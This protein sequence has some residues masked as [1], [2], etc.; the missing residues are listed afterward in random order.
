MP[1]PLPRLERTGSSVGC[2]PALR[3]P[4]PSDRRVS[5]SERLSRPIQG[6]RTFRPAH[7]HLGFAKDFSGGFSRTIT[8]LDCS[9]GY[10]ANRQFPGRDLHPLAFETQE[11]S[12]RFN[13]SR[14]TSL[15]AALPGNALSPRSKTS[16]LP[17]AATLPSLRFRLPFSRVALSTLYFSFSLPPI[18]GPPDRGEAHLLLH[19]PPRHQ[20]TLGYSSCRHDQLAVRRGPATTPTPLRSPRTASG[21]ES[22]LSGRPRSGFPP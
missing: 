2:S 21:V 11:V 5:S 20:E 9:S 4:S 19:A 15:R 14:Q 1:T 3:R 18:P 16:P 7:L 17:L 6:S 10:R 8:R 22:S 13:S 12:P